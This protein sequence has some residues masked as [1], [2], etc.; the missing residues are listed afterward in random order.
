L[1]LSV[2]M[3]MSVSGRGDCIHFSL[4]NQPV[5]SALPMAGLRSIGRQAIREPTALWVQIRIVMV[6]P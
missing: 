5:R 1:S 6:H 2:V 4:V 3:S